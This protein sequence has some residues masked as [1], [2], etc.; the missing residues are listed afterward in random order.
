MAEYGRSGMASKYKEQIM[1]HKED[2]QH[3]EYEKEKQ[4]EKD[5]QRQEDL[6]KIEKLDEMKPRSVELY[7]SKK[8]RGTGY[9]FITTIEI[10]I[11]VIL[12]L[13]AGC[14]LYSLY[15]PQVGIDYLEKIKQL[16]QAAIA[17]IH[18]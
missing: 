14:T 9:R 1:G 3:E 17:I 18:V 8:R 4:V 11:V 13:L 2:E 7:I 5:K 16:Q 10:I 15:N 6:N 12:G